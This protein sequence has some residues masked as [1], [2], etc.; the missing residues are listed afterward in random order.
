MPNLYINGGIVTIRTFSPKATVKHPGQWRSQRDKAQRDK[1]Q[2]DKLPDYRGPLPDVL[3]CHSSTWPDQTRV[4]PRSPQGAVRWK[5]L[6]TRLLRMCPMCQKNFISR[7]PY[8]QLCKLVPND[9]VVQKLGINPYG[10]LTWVNTKFC[11]LGLQHIFLILDIHVMVNWHLSKHS[12]R[13]LLSHDHITG[14]GLELMKLLCWPLT[15]YCFSIGPQAHIWLICGDQ[16]RGV[17]KPINANPGLKVNQSMFFCYTKC[18]FNY[19]FWVISPWCSL[20][21]SLYSLRVTYRFYSVERQTILLVK[22]RPL[23]S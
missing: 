3:N 9:E 16:G 7:A 15:K 11:S 5:I 22:G 6:R 2:R 13:W 18:F 19:C 20:T 14:S 21:L 4:S 1:A 8:R 12:I 23:R 17:R 10:S